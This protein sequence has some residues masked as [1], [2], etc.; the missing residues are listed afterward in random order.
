MQK[1]TPRTGA[2][3]RQLANQYL[4][5]VKR[6]RRKC[7]RERQLLARDREQALRNHEKTA[8]VQFAHD[9]QR[10]NAAEASSSGLQQCTEDVKKE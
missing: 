2:L 9:R 6:Y 10:T 3:H 1:Q 5:R 8:S 7:T 4:H